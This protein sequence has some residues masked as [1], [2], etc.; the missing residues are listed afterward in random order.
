LVTF[1]LSDDW[2][3]GF[4]ADLVIT[5]NGPTAIAG[6]T[7]EFDFDR[8]IT[9]IW[10]ARVVSRVGSHNVLRN[11]AWNPVNV[12]NGGR[13]EFGFQGAP[14]NVGDGPA[15]DVLNGVELP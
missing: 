13:V 2:G 8:E 5:N 1:H 3:A 15:N 7:L 9:N 11:E 12:A 6:W 10:N 14:G 4:V